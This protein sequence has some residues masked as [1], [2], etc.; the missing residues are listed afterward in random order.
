MN[1]AILITFVLILLV[2]GGY[3]I[4]FSQ[5]FNLKY[6]GKITLND[7]EYNQLILEKQELRIMWARAEQ[8]AVMYK[9]LYEALKNKTT[10]KK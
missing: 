9:D 7:T 5:E 10:I 1:K 8:K 2:G 6:L 3:A 4:T